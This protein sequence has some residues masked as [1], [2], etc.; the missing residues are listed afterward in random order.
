[1]HCLEKILSDSTF[2]TSDRLSAF[3]RYIVTETLADR[4]SRLKGYNVALSVFSRGEKFDPQTNSVVRVEATRLRKQLAAYY[5]GPGADDPIEIRVNRGS[6]VPEFVERTPASLA[7]VEAETSASETVPPSR[8][9]VPAPLASKRWSWAGAA[10]AAVVLAAVGTAYWLTQTKPDNDPPR[11]AQN[12]VWSLPPSLAVAQLER[13]ADS[14]V[15]QFQASA[16]AREVATA[17]GRFETVRVREVDPNATAAPGTEYVLAGGISRH[18]DQINISFRLVRTND[19]Q[20]VWTKTY[21]QLPAD[22]TADRRLN[23]IADLTSTL[24]RTYGVI[25]ADR[26]RQTPELGPTSHGFEC[27]IYG[28]RY[29][30]GPTQHSFDTVRACLQRTVE[31]EP[32]ASAGHAMLAMILIDGYIKGYHV[33]RD[34]ALAQATIAANEAVDLAPQSAR[35]HLA[36]FLARFHEERFTDAFES[37]QRA[38]ALNPFSIES[39]SRVGSGYALR[40]EREASLRLLNEVQASVEN[41]ATWL[42]FY[43][44]LNAYMA[45]DAE[46]AA[47]HAARSQTTR[48]PLGLIAR[49]I[50]AARN[51][52]THHIEKGKMLLAQRFPQFADD[53]PGALSRLE[54]A[55]PIRERILADLAAVDAL[56]IQPPN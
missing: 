25:F 11:V 26:Y 44:F 17:L 46:L 52:D 28:S 15:S 22:L 36:L 5:A 16:L 24:G 3:L 8:P 37:A 35:A 48:T 4:G 30:N 20:I 9:T 27:I 40:G 49:I 38:L 45:G 47:R 53:I 12:P 19:S 55:P 56:K 1:M 43:F 14:P 23:I 41:G 18:T 33:A 10:L 50:V 54:M 6:Y 2:A 13:P 7:S 42:E 39:K 34:D 31:A 21:N 51:G 32:K 29:L